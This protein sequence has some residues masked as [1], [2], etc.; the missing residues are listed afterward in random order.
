M[1]TTSSQTFHEAWDCPHCGNRGLSAFNCKQCPGCGASLSE[2][3]VYRTRTPVENYSFEGHDVICAHCEERNEKRFS[4][5]GCGAPL[6]DGDDKIV[7]SFTYRSAHDETPPPKQNPQ[8]ETPAPTP[9]PSVNIREQGVVS[10]TSPVYNR[11]SNSNRKWWYIGGGVTTLAIIIL[12]IWIFS[13]LQAV[14]PATLT[15][16]RAHWS[17]FLALEDYRPRNETMEVEEGSFGSPP[18]DAYKIDRTHVLVRTEPIYEDKTVPRTCVNISSKSNGDGT[19]T[20]T[21]STYDCSYTEKV[22]VGTKKIWGT[23]YDY[24]VDRWKAIAPLTREGWGQEPNFPSFTTPEHC[25]SHYPTHGCIRT[26]GQPQV[27][28]TIRAKGTFRGLKSQN[29]RSTER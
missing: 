22:Q 13:Q 23:R 24:T 10:T 9:T 28:F 15:A 18:S 21:K 1:A 27:T 29:H 14:I 25:V 12:S 7:A 11:S 2:G 17:Y 4:C 26:A 16:D 20:E 19:W 5:H 3:S 8:S 6:N